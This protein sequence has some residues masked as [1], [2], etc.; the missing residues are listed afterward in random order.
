METKQK[1]FVADDGRSIASQRN[2]Q[3]STKISTKGP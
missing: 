2:I 3:R 1:D